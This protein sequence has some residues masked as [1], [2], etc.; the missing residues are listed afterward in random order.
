MTKSNKTRKP[1]ISSK[2]IYLAK[3]IFNGKPLPAPPENS[4][5]KDLNQISALV[6]RFGAGA[7]RVAVKNFGS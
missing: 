6:Y 2:M 3:D 4:S 5:R 7:V 1:T